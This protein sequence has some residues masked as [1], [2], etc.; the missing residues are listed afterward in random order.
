MR[1]G[2]TIVWDQAFLVAT[3][4]GLTCNVHFWRTVA[5]SII[6]RSANVAYY[7]GQGASGTPLRISPDKS[8]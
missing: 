6:L 3:G 1:T 4:R 7:I 8:R 2:G 5:A